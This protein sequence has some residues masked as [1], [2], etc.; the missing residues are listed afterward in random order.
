MLAFACFRNNPK[1]RLFG[2]KKLSQGT[3][4]H[5]WMDCAVLVCSQCFR[6]AQLSFHPAVPCVRHSA[7]LFVMITSMVIQPLWS[8]RTRVTFT[9]DDGSSTSYPATIVGVDPSNDI[10]VLKIDAPSS[11]LL[12][13][14][15]GTSADLK[16]GQS[17]YAI[18]NPGGLSRTQTAG[19]V[20]GL[21]RSIPSPTGI[22]IPG[23]IQTDASIN[24]GAEPS[25]RINIPTLRTVGRPVG[26]SSNT[27]DIVQQKRGFFF[28]FSSQYTGLVTP[29]ITYCYYVKYYLLDLSFKYYL[30][31]FW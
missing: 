20:S 5:E 3:C 6:S 26:S 21:K 24:A 1:R 12:P 19:V 10:A 22:L 13:V 29:K 9:E 25:I 14:T 8:Q 17:V 23:I 18:G 16:V 2:N 30:I 11:K 27:Q 7:Y 15:V 4:W 28:L 31:S